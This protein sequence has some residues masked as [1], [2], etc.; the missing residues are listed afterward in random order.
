MTIEYVNVKCIA[1]S[2]LYLLIQPSAMLTAEL[3]VVSCYDYGTIFSNDSG[4]IELLA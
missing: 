4:Q 3:F 1:F 2:T